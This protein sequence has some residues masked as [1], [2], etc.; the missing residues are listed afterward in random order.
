VGTLSQKL[1][2]LRVYARTNYS[3][4][5]IASAARPLESGKLTFLPAATRL[6]LDLT[7]VESLNESLLCQGRC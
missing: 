3:H 4:H 5:A 7:E 2:Q 6:I 1:L